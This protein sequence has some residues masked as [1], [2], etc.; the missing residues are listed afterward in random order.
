MVGMVGA[1]AVG[2]G[3]SGGRRRRL[4]EALL[5]GCVS[6]LRR[7]RSHNYDNKDNITLTTTIKTSRAREQVH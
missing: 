1:V 5:E 7:S 4:R 3:I 2:V 6:Q